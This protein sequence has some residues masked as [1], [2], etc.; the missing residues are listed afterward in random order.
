MTGS[1]PAAQ[2][3]ACIVHALLLCGVLNPRLQIFENMVLW[4]LPQWDALVAQ[5]LRQCGAGWTSSRWR[6]A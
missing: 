2:E 1:L 5:G 6:T 3:A 4:G